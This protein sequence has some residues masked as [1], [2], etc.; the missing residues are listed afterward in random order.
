VLEADP[1]HAAPIFDL[2][3]RKAVRRNG[4]RLAVAAPQPTALDGGA[5]AQARY[6]PGDAAAFC[7][8]L[9]GALGAAGYAAEGP[10]AEAAGEIAE[11]LRAAPDVVV[12]WGERLA[13]GP[14]GAAAVQAL[15]AIAAALGIEAQPEGGLIELPEATNAR[16]L[17]EVG[18]LPGAGPGLAEAP[19]GIDAPAIAAAL[20]SGE[21]AAALLFEADPAGEGPDGEGWRRALAAADFVACVAMF[22]T[23]TAKLADVVLPAESYAEKDGTI[24]HPDG[25]LQRLRP[26]IA[27]RGQL[28]MGWQWL[29]ELSALLGDEPGLHTGPM[30]LTALADEV[31]FYAGVT[32][33]EIGGRGVRWQEREAGGR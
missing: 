5:T 7:A 26:G 3:V 16:G 2:R 15:L 14:R 18:C 20:E 9:A 32:H 10:Y 23:A 22:E 6:A 27:H 30:V 4:A 24:T 8:A 19:A 13:A 29:C 1:V 17:R 28:R 12:L 21:L 25:R 11:L 31:S 33:D